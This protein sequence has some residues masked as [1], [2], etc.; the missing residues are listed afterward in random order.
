MTRYRAIEN[1][2]SIV[3][4]TFGG[5]T[6]AV[7]FCGRILSFTQGT[8][9]KDQYSNLSQVYTKGRNTLYSY[10]G[11]VWNWLYIIGVFLV[12]FIKFPSSENELPKVNDSEV[13]HLETQG[14]T[15]NV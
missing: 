9:E 6:I 13:N 14:Q 8:G 10:I 4:N 15:E 3:K 11:I 1:G 12:I 5:T 7:D 2:Y